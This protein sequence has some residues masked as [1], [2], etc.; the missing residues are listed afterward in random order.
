MVP[1]RAPC[2]T[3]WQCVRAY[4]YGAQQ[5]HGGARLTQTHTRRQQARAISGRALP[6]GRAPHSSTHGASCGAGQHCN[7]QSPCRQR[8]TQRRGGQAKADHV[9]EIAPPG[10]KGNVA[11]HALMAAVACCSQPGL[12]NRAAVRRAVATPTHPA[13]HARDTHSTPGPLRRIPSH[14]RTQPRVHPQPQT[15]A[16]RSR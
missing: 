6:H 1:R 2:A 10:V 13:E 7:P 16:H 14:R 9:D 3:V 4:T 15:A 11:S 12:N 5:P 8:H